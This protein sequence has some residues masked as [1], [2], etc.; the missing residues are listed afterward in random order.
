MAVRQVTEG[1]F[2]TTIARGIVLLDWW[3][4]WC[5]PCRMFAPIFDAASERHPD[6]VFGKIDTEAEAGLASAFDI[7]AIPTLMALRDGVLLA[8][9]PGVLPAGTL[10]ELIARVRDLDMDGVRQELEAQK[11]GRQP[12]SEEMPPARQERGG[13]L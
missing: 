1:N 9:V 6:V 4:G 3:A 2:E 5:G 12:V 8:S 7:R 10:D 13:S 11:A